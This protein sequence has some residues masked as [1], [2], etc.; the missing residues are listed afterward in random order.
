MADNQE[1]SRFT[2]Q[3]STVQSGETE[4][5][6]RTMYCIVTVASYSEPGL[7]MERARGW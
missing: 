3:L 5:T 1:C 7:K 4:T 6:T 2:L